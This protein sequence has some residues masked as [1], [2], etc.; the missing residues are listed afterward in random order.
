M[1]GPAVLGGLGPEAPGAKDRYPYPRLGGVGLLAIGELPVPGTESHETYDLFLSHATADKV[2]VRTLADE[3][4]KLGLHR[5][6]RRARART[7]R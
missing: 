6:L 1:T 2:W 4:E 5:L 7:G 3:L